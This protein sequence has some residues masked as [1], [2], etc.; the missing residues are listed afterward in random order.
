MAVAIMPFE[1][2]P[3]GDPPD[4]NLG[5]TPAGVGHRGW[6]FCGNSVPMATERDSLWFLTAAVRGDV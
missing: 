1:I 4:D 2:Q 5:A 3:N 6:C